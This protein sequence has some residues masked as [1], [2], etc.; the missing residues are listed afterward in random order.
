MLEFSLKAAAIDYEQLADRAQQ[1]RQ[2]ETP[3]R[4]ELHTFG[5]R[6]VTTEEGRRAVIANMRRLSEAYGEYRCVVHVPYQSVDEVTKTDFDAG[7][8]Q[9]SI[10]LAQEIEAEGVV[11][12]RY[13]GLTY[14]P[15]PSRSNRPD[16]IAGFNDTILELAKGA[17]D[18]QLMVENVGHYSLLPRDGQHFLAGPLDHF[19]PWE[20]EAF[21]DFIE[22]N[23][24]D[25]VTLFAD[26]AHATLS[27][28]MFN[29]C[30]HGDGAIRDDPR[31]RWILDDDLQQ[32]DHLHPFDFVRGDMTYLHVSD[33]RL[34]SDEETRTGRVSE[35]RMIEATCSEGLEV[36]TG[37]LPWEKLG[38]AINPGL[39]PVLVLEVEPGKGDSHQSNGAQGRSLNAL[40]RALC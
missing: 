9:Q 5:A 16:A 39:G 3:I 24:L 34:L 29:L 1:C 36:G 32:A 30:R 2:L 19:F 7:Q 38:A 26:T 12:H 21:R 14:G 15:A 17:D 6:D 11:L 20:M 23:A 8:V 37:D 40:R 35:E 25:N 4:I 18:I 10:E 27:A 28:N 22:D 33:S 13:W 31:F